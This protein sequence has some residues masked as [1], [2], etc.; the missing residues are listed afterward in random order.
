MAFV[1]DDQFTKRF[2][3]NEIT[4]S[5][6][7]AAQRPF[8]ESIRRNPDAALA[9]KLQKREVQT[10]LPPI[11][12]EDSELIALQLQEQDHLEQEL[13][14][15]EVAQRIADGWQRQNEDGQVP[16]ANE[17]GRVPRLN[18]G[19]RVPRL[20]EALNSMHRTRPS[21]EMN[22]SRTVRAPSMMGTLPSSSG[23]HVFGPGTLIDSSSDDTE[24]DGEPSILPRPRPRLQHHRRGPDQNRFQR[25]TRADENGQRPG[26]QP[27]PGMFR[28]R[29]N[30]DDIP[31]RE[32]EQR[33]DIVQ[34]PIYRNPYN[35]LARLMNYGG[36][37]RNPIQNRNNRIP[38][39]SDD[40]DV[41]DYEALWELQERNGDVRSKGLKAEEIGRIPCHK[42]KSTPGLY[43]TLKSDKNS[44]SICLNEYKDGE[45]IK[46][47]PCFHSYHK[48]CVDKWLMSQAVCPVCRGNIKTH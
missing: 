36:Y 38:F 17:G 5:A 39:R 34:P 45:S 7:E 11:I 18:D 1:N 10:P 44:C 48:T 26:L 4:A 20:N 27:L 12:D 47:L 21:N 41:D 15:A 29:E 22:F 25:N 30:R 2:L 23:L 28:F 42:F 3:Q 8:T 19:G 6:Y 14:D 13:H 43:K 16:H 46:T 33:H 35:P 40:I 37:H 32:Q 31:D 24:V 9:L